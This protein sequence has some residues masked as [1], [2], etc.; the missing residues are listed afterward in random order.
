MQV[1]VISSSQP[2]QQQ[3][4]QNQL[5]SMTNG[6]V[7]Q[8]GQTKNQSDMQKNFQ[9]PKVQ[10]QKVN[11]GGTQ[12]VNNV[13]N[14]QQANQQCVVSQGMPTAQIINQSQMQSAP[15]LQ[16]AATVPQFWATPQQVMLAPQNSFYIRSQPDG[17]QLF[18]QQSPQPQAIQAPQQQTI[19]NINQSQQPQQTQSQ[20]P[21]TQATQ[22]HINFINFMYIHIYSRYLFC[23]KIKN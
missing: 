4:Q 22:V 19:V 12:N 6:N 3:Q 16:S 20:T 23:M 7:S 10:M 2:Q 21:Q 15:W 14:Q 13:A 11:N 1:N 8:T 17:T 18:L 5:I 9:S